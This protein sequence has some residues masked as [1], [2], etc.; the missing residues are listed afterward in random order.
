MLGG[1]GGI[2]VWA[3]LSARSRVVVDG[4]G[5][6]LQGVFRR[7]EYDAPVYGAPPALC[8]AFE[9]VAERRRT[10]LRVWDS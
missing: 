2:A 3:A 4:A 1:A 9:A 6:T 10:S 5:V 8:R 7:H